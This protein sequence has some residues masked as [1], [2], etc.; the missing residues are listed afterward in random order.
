M[1]KAKQDSQVHSQAAAGPAGDIPPASLAHNG[2]VLG[3]TPGDEIPVAKEE[4]KIEARFAI[5]DT[6][7]REP[8]Y[9]Q[10]LLW[11]E[12][13]GMAPEAVLM[14]LAAGQDP[15]GFALE[16][17][18]M[19][20]LVWDFERLPLIPTTW[21]SG[22]LIRDIEFRGKWPDGDTVFRPALPSLRSLKCKNVGVTSINL[23]LVPGLT[24]LDCSGNEL[25]A[26]DLSPVTELE[27]LDCGG[28]QLTTLDLSP[29]PELEWLGCGKNQLTSLD[30]SP[31]TKL[32]SLLCYFNPLTT[33]DLTLV[34][35]LTKLGCW[36]NG[37][38]APISPR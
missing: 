17:G 2:D 22:L 31:V 15:D 28:N 37:L 38:T 16:D 18:A 23:T 29:V 35:G 20:C 19:V 7:L 12:A 24:K 34:P 32:E 5:K 33:L 6:L 4:E 3:G 9:Q 27:W 14:I 30:L 13:L 1:A 10:I 21:V 25:T 36:V 11:A 8:D 26:L